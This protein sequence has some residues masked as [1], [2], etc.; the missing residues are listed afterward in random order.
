MMFNMEGKSDGKNI[1]EPMLARMKYEAITIKE[2]RGQTNKEKKSSCLP[3]REE[4]PGVNKWAK[5]KVLAAYR[6]NGRRHRC[7]R[8]KQVQER[9]IGS[10]ERDHKIDLRKL[11][12]NPIAFGTDDKDGTDETGAMHREDIRKERRMESPSSMNSPPAQ[13]GQY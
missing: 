12:N 1:Q 11:K 8:R 6:K 9:L 5:W 4:R 2:N 3:L 7:R 13:F 10:R